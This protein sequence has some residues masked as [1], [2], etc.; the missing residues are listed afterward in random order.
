MR[1][2]SEFDVAWEAELE[3]KQVA[4]QQLA[5]ENKAKATEELANFYLE[6]EKLREANQEKNRNEEQLYQEK[7]EADLEGENPWSR[8]VSLVCATVQ[9]C[10]LLSSC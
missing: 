10:A 2:R 3:T 1:N 8:V 9:P 4:H 7:L 5:D 6:R